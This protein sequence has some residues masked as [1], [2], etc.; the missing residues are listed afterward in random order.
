MSAHRRALR[1][2]K[3]S[4]SPAAGYLWPGRRC[5]VLETP[6]QS[7]VSGNRCRFTEWQLFG[8]RFRSIFLFFCVSYVLRGGP[9]PHVTP[10]GACPRRIA[11][12][13]ACIRKRMLH[14]ETW[15]STEIL[16]LYRDSDIPSRVRELNSCVR[17]STRE[18]HFQIAVAPPYAAYM[19]WKNKPTMY[20]QRSAHC[21]LAKY[22]SFDVQEKPLSSF[23][24]II[25]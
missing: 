7:D 1:L 12:L 8:A 18:S 15:Y 11:G 3:K 24:H 16:K 13:C 22:S 6:A 10:E 21:R 5:Y 4:K 25:Q 17:S 19:L 20:G 23:R 14:R 2:I 9:L